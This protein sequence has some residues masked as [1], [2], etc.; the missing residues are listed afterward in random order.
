M[1]EHNLAV[2]ER[3]GILSVAGHTEFES[4]RGGRSL[5]VRPRT[6]ERRVHKVALILARRP[7][8]EKRTLPDL[9]AQGHS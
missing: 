1:G 3:P 6:L 9:V 8:S 7:L 2:N 5:V 4:N